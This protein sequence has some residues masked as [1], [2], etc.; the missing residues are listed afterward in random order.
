MQRLNGKKSVD[1]KELRSIEEKLSKFDARRI[2]IVPNKDALKRYPED[3]EVWDWLDFLKVSG[4]DT[5]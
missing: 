1:G 4:S 5:K 3:I 2:L